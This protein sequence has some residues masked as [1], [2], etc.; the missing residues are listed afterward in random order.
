[1][2]KKYKQSDDNMPVMP[3]NLRFQLDEWV[4]SYYPTDYDEI[5][6]QR[7]F[8]K[9]KL[10]M[11]FWSWLFELEKPFEHTCLSQPLGL[12]VKWPYGKRIVECANIFLKMDENHRK[13]VV[14]ARITEPPIWWRGDP[15]ETFKRIIHETLK[16]NSL[17]SVEK[18]DYKKSLMKQVR[19]LQDAHRKQA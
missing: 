19:V 11:Q 1:M 3:L 7:E 10:P 6:K 17:N 14:K 2:N 16:F 18:Y 4:R 5:F 12:W 15:I 9:G 13:L 8:M